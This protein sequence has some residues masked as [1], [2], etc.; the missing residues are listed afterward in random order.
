MSAT[1]GKTEAED[2]QI[3]LQRA[4]IHREEM[5]FT[6]DRIVRRAISLRAST[7]GF[8][9]IANAMISR[10]SLALIGI[11]ELAFVTLNRSGENR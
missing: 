5:G 6:P 9:V 3:R 7:V 8:K 2:P 11:L 1:P 10:E 4:R